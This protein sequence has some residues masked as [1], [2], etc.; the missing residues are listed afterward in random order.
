VKTIRL[1]SSV[2]CLPRLTQSVRTSRAIAHTAGLAQVSGFKSQVFRLSAAAFAFIVLAATGSAHLGNTLADI[3][4][5]R[6]K[7]AGKP[8]KNKAIWLF[9][10]NDG[11]L[12]YAVKFDA[13]GRSIAETLKPGLIGRGLH[14]EIASDFIKAQMEIL[15]GSKTTRVLE[16]GTKYTFAGQALSVAENEFV[17]VDEPRGFLLVWV[18]GS[19]PSVT[20]LA[21]AAVK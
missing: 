10:G 6:G 15:E 20:V 19:L 21:P 2:I 18:K 1:L 7:P 3:E 17:V 11:Q 5:M 12:V 13:D 4:K 16:P 14:I 8:D 9:E